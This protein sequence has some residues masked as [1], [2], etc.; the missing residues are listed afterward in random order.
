MFGSMCLFMIAWVFALSTVKRWYNVRRKIEEQIL[1]EKDTALLAEKKALSEVRA[2]SD[3][4]ANMSHEIRTPMN[5]IIGYSELL[6][7]TNLD[8]KQ[9]EYLATINSSSNLLLG[10]IN[11]VL[12]LSKLEAGKVELE[13]INFDLEYLV[14]D[15]F[16]MIQARLE[17]K[18]IQTYIDIAS[19][20]PHSMKADP[21]RLRQILLNLLGNAVKFT[22]E[23]EIGV[24][25]RKITQRGENVI[26][27]FRIKD[28]GI[29]I[30]HDGQKR[31]F[32]SFS[33]AESSTT[34]KFGGTGLGLAITKTLV[35]AMDGK[36][37]V[38]SEEGA[39]SEFIFKVSLQ[40]GSGYDHKKVL[41]LSRM[42]LKGRRV[43]I[44][45][46]NQR[47]RE[48]LRS[49][50]EEIAL[51]V[52]GCLDTAQGALNKIDDLLQNNILPDVILSDI[53]FDDMT[54]VQFIDKLRSHVKGRNIKVIAIPANITVGAASDAKKSGF[55]GF[56]A[57]PIVRSDLEKVVSTILG[58]YREEKTIV[59]RHMAAE[60]SCKGVKVLV[61]DDSIPNQA[62][63][64]AYFD[65]IG[66]EGDYV[67][68]GLEAL[69]ALRNGTHYD[70]CLMDMQMPEMDGAEATRIIRKEISEDLPII[71]LTA[72]AMKED[73]EKCIQAGMN[74]YLIKPISIVKLKDTILQYVNKSV[75]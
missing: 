16:K 32:K 11:D 8:E 70:L 68:N 35:E 75:A 62:L 64:K 29:G 18:N 55:D 25:V 1:K 50:C 30:S 69:D 39:G 59:T 61:V 37:W 9:Q 74:D 19:D 10:I 51:E 34:R 56:L 45:D 31:L 40:T 49:Y 72:A 17:D 43:F 33:Q 20:V 48:I 22:E 21:T 53:Q 65:N 42:Q 66:C 60:V 57:K 24:I 41:P 54:G 71:A 13:S 38:E 15:V 46:G 2:K 6:T 27:E 23:G 12:D 4:L 3:F 73:K 44:V 14:T 5:A 58:D 47:A 36:V 63:V 26:I 28:T 52:V 7:K 67:N